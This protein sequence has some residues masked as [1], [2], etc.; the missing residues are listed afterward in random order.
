MEHGDER[1]RGEGKRTR[2]HPVGLPVLPILLWEV[3]TNRTFGGAIL[4]F[5]LDD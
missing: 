1:N 2:Y 5:L 4:K 3:R